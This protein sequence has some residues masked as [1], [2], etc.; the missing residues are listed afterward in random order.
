MQNIEQFIEARVSRRI[1]AED[2]AL[3]RLERREAR[4]EKMIGTLIR[5]GKEINYTMPMNGQYREGKRHDLVAYLIRNN[6]A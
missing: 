3:T 5:D 4:A 6:H 1:K 2:R